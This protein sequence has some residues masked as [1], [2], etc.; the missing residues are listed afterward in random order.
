M[1]VFLWILFFLPISEALMPLK[2]IMLHGELGGSIDIRC[3]LK[4]PP[5]RYYFCREIKGLCSTVV[6]STS[7]VGPDY[8]NR[9][10]LKLLPDEKVFLVELRNLKEEDSGSYACGIG[11][12][13]DKGKTWKVILTV[14]PEYNSIWGEPDYS[15]HFPFPWSEISSEASSVT[16]QVSTTL[17]PLEEIMLY[18]ELG[19]SIDIRCPLKNPPQKYYLCRE[20]S[21]GQCSTVVSSTSFVGPDYQNRVSLKLLP[22]EMVFLVELRNLKEEDSGSYACGI[23][24]KR[25]KRKTLKVILTVSPEYNPFWGEP[26]Y[27]EHLPLP[28]SGISN[29]ASSVITQASTSAPWT[30]PGQTQPPLDPSPTSPI[31]PQRATLAAAPTF[32]TSRSSVTSKSLHL[33]RLLRP[34]TVSYSHNTRLRGESAS[35]FGSSMKKDGGF[36]ILIPATLGIIL[37]MLLG[38]VLGRSLQKRRV[39]SRRI[40]RLTMRM[41]ALEASQ[42]T[43]SHLHGSHQRR[44]YRPVSNRLRSQYNIYSACPRQVQR[45]NQNGE[46]MPTGGPGIAEPSPPT[47][48]SK[49]A[50]LQAPVPVKNEYMSTYSLCVSEQ[51]DSDSHDY[52]NVSC[53]TQIPSCAPGLRFHN[54]KDCR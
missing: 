7:F 19:G 35:Y 12:K 49:T 10:S 33:R 22:E 3:P 16:T 2:E 44:F 24:K 5:Q 9:V 36:H 15:E 39:L 1:D 34:S 51:E 46:Q 20:I 45:P 40:N 48:V 42:R 23:C 53:L 17:E 27:S 18:G 28:W 54:S 11:R 25:D 4:N 50:Q 32:Q 26:D 31:L 21:P 8:Q 30:Q 13:T 14:T 37:M 38:L 29:E 47:Q 6:S 43:H 41:S 52:I